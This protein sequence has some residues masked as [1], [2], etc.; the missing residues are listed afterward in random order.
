MYFGYNE[1]MFAKKTHQKEAIDIRETTDKVN[2]AVMDRIYRICLLYNGIVAT[3]VT[4]N[5]KQ[6]DGY[7]QWRRN[8]L[9]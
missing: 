6:H 1:S 4:L 3:C 2:E 5:Q 8:S 7:H 9:S